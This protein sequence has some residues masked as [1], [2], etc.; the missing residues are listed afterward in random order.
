MQHRRGLRSRRAAADPQIPW[1]EINPHQRAK[2]LTAAIICEANCFTKNLRFILKF[3]GARYAGSRGEVA[4]IV[5][6][7]SVSGVLLLPSTLLPTTHFLLI[8]RTKDERTNFLIYIQ[9]G[10][11]RWS[12][13]KQIEIIMQE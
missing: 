1:K 4:R 6:A 2:F 13:G 5:A 10:T 3:G 8:Q 11:S 9:N 7:T 12:E